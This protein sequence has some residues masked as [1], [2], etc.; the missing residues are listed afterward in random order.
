MRLKRLRLV[1]FRNYRELDLNLDDPWVLIAGANAQGKTNLLEA[2]AIACSGRSPRRASDAEIIRWGQDR[3]RATAS[4]ATDGRGTLELTANLSSCGRRQVMIN[5]TTRRLA[6]LVGLVGMVLFAVDDL[7]IIKRDPSARR[8]FLDTELAALSKPY[9]WNLTRYRRGVDQRNRLLREMREK[10]RSPAELDSWDEQ[11]LG[12]GAVIVEK[13]A[14]FL[15][16]LAAAGTEA[17]QRLTGRQ[18]SLELPYRPA[19]GPEQT[20]PKIASASADAQ[21]LRR[22][23]R[24]LLSR[25]LA[26]HRQEQIERGMTLSGPQRD[27]FDIIGGGV[28]LHRF[29]S[30]GD[31]R[32][33]AIAL[34]LGLL[35]VVAGSV[36]EP[37]LLLLDDVLSEL[38][39]ERRAGLFEALGGAAQT[40]VTATDLESV[41][42]GVR[43]AARTLHVVNGLVAASG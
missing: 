18:E 26:Q 5:G 30:Q 11:L 16:D 9:Y 27:D 20:W 8:R 15:D 38:D 29:G 22:R 17:Y 25:A 43:A 12:C 42:A 1:D 24:E 33:A 28:D 35:Q 32:S 34:R 36:G 19:L 2:A 37:P 40:I 6:D 41:P 14:G 39:P 13:R 23:V 7:D 31:Q 3:A 4:V 10:L 21:E